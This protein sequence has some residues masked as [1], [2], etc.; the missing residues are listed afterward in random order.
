MIAGLIC[1][2][3]VHADPYAS[4]KEKPPLRKAFLKIS[5]CLEI[6]EIV[7]Q[8]EELLLDLLCFQQRI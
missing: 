2:D 5:R 6:P 7:L 4:K 1:N 8:F 3:P